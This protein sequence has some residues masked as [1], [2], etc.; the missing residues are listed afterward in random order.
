MNKQIEELSTKYTQAISGEAGMVAATGKA[1][2]AGYAHEQ[3]ASLPSNFA[4][5][6][7]GCGDPVTF[8]GIELGQTVLDLGSG[9][10]LDLVL[11]AEKVGSAGRVIGIDVTPAMIERARQ[12]IAQTEHRN[13]EVRQGFIESLPV[14]TGSVDWVISNC[15]INLSPNKKQV[16]EEIARVLKPGGRMLV[17][18]IVAE[19]LPWWVR[20]SGL[21]S[22]ACVSGAISESAYLSGLTAAGLRA[23]QIVARQHYEPVQMAAVVVEALPSAMTNITCCG[24]PLARTLLTRVAKPIADKLWSARIYAEKPQRTPVALPTPCEQR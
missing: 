1:R 9:V 11:A 7:F 2:F 4:D 3:L 15:V 19:N 24:R 10:G 8:S 12:N 17:S 20:R 21:L 13:I 18:D 22:A 23:C 6:S 14:E 16:F 5:S